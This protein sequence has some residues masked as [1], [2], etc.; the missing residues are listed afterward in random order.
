LNEERGTNNEKRVARTGLRTAA[1]LLVVV[2]LITVMTRPHISQIVVSKSART[3]R[4]LDAEGGEIARYTIAVGRSA[5]GR[6][7]VEGDR[8]TP[9]GEYFV[10]VKNP[11]S[12]FHLSLGLNYPNAEDGRRGY[13]AGLISN[14]ELAEI[15]TAE[16][17]RRRP[18]WKTALGGEI[19]IHGHGHGRDGTAGCIAVTDAE[20]EE[21]YAL[22]YVGTPVRIEP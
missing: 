19:F 6:K 1:V 2:A 14:E 13:A 5:E 21:I 10:C 7:E 16:S 4:L 17:E 12:K 9:E 8:R 11:N 18:P 22:V 3:L 20:I 15:E